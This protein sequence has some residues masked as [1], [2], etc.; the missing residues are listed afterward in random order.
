MPDRVNASSMYPVSQV[1]IWSCLL[2]SWVMELGG[3][4]QNL[5][6][7]LVPSELIAHNTKQFWASQLLYLPDYSSG[8]ELQIFSLLLAILALAAQSLDNSWSTNQHKVS[9]L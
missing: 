2:V 7:F 8:W 1:Y 3:S 4:I 5:H 9:S 6:H